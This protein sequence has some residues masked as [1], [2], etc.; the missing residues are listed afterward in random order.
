MIEVEDIALEKLGELLLM[1]DQKVVQ[2]F[3]SHAPQ[4]AFT[5]SICPA[6]VRL[7]VRRTLMLLV[8]ATRAKCCPNLRSLTLIRYV[9]V[10]PY[11]VASRSGTRDPGIG[12]RARHI[13][14]HDFP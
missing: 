1:E 7:G 6:R 5:H 12:G 2:T 4:K 10:C 14:M 11:G 13:H 9:G 8:A 3:S